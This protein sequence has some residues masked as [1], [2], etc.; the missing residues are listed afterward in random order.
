[1]MAMTLLT[2][3]FMACSEANR[4]GPPGEPAGDSQA[5]AARFS[6]EREA[7]VRETIRARGVTDSRVLAA[8]RKVPRHL[9]VPGELIPYAHA[10]HPLAIGEGQTISQ[11]YIVAVMTELAGVQPGD[12]VLE[13]GTGS[14]YGAAVLAEVAGQVHTIEIIE[15][16]GRTAEARL[17]WLGYRN[18][19]VRVGDGYRGWP[20]AAPF[21]AIIV[22]AAPGHVPQP[23][24]DQLKTG[25]RLVIPV[26]DA[27]QELLVITRTADGAVMRSVLPVRFVPMTG[28]AQ[29]R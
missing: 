1:M 29:A 15:T 9:F 3:F 19:H 21:A 2:P 23:L 18:V 16:L 13:I 5:A 17:A 4:F 25:G 14:G 7:M 8:M 27:W 6:E 10:D 22:T 11:P 26:G 28:E 20:E 12:M 24:V